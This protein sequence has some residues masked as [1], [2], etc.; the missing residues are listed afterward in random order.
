MTGH[1]K[2][3]PSSRHLCDAV[4]AEMGTLR[5][6]VVRTELG[7]PCALHQPGDNRFA[8][9][10][11]SKKRPGIIIFF[12]S[13]PDMSLSSLPSG[14]SVERRE[15][16]SGN[17]S[18]EFAF[19]LKLSDAAGVRDVARLLSVLS[20]PL[21]VRR[22]RRAK[23][24]V[25]PATCPP[26]EVHGCPTFPEGSVQRIAVNRYERDPQAREACITYYGTACHVCGFDFV[27]VY[28]EVMAGFTHVHHLKPLATVRDG[29]RVDPV[30]DLRPVCPNCHAVIHRHEPPYSI[31]EVQQFLQAAGKDRAIG[32]T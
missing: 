8:Y 16:F 5:P 27:A 3:G 7:T 17:W 10:Y 2:G 28:G 15:K 29:Y 25:R 18:K 22:R 19:S 20:C 13:D 14:V 21:A 12:R 30:E 6:G 26:E 11:H 32:C 31:Q 23:A 4:L 9:V 24:V 1:A